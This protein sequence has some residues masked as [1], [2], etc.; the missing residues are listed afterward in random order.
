MTIS[1]AKKTCSRGHIYDSAIYGDNCPFCP[2]TVV[3]N[4]NVE[5]TVSVGSADCDIIVLHPKVC[6][7]HLDIIIKEYVHKR[8][9]VIVD[10]VFDKSCYAVFSDRSRNGTVVDN[11]KIHYATKK[12]LIYDVDGVTGT[13]MIGKSQILLAG[14]VELKWEDVIAAKIRKQSQTI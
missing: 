10:N 14:E 4:E 3:N 2:R 9:D 8:T 7:H 13:C 11:E 6:P 1:M 12:I 5:S